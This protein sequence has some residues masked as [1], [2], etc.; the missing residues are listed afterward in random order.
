M[1]G[2]LF[3]VGNTTL[4]PHGGQAQTISSNS[5]VLVNG[6]PVATISDTTLVA[7]CPFTVPTGKPQPC[8]KVQWLVPATRVVVNGQPALLQTSTGLCLSPEQIPQGP[9][10]VTVNQT[11]VIGT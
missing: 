4:C 7:G 10:M 1:P 8:V 3:H 2:P 9:P 5:R 6:M 11:R